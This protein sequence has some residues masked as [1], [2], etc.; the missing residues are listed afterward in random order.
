M[1]RRELD[2]DEILHFARVCRVENV[3]KPYLQALT[4]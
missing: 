4:S 3:M 1:V 2:P